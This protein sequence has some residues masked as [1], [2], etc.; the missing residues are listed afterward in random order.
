MGYATLLE[1]REF[2]VGGVQAL[3]IPRREID[4]LYTWAFLTLTKEDIGMTTA[5]QKF[6]QAIIE[7]T[8]LQ[9]VGTINAYT[10]IMAIDRFTSLVRV[11]PMHPTVYQI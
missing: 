1:D 7:E 9:V 10:A 2:N 11:S 6:R 8:P 4:F 3:I 5:G